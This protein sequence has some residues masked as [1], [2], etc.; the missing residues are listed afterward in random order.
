MPQISPDF[1]PAASLAGGVLIGAAATLYLACSGR[2]SGLSSIIRGTLLKSQGFR[3]KSTFLGG[4]GCGAIVWE[5]IQPTVYGPVIEASPSASTAVPALAGTL[6]GFGTMLANGCTS[7]HGVCGLPRLSKRSF[8]AVGTFMATGVA[9][10]VAASKTNSFGLSGLMRTSTQRLPIISV[11]YAAAM[12]ALPAWA[13]L[14]SLRAP[15]VSTADTNAPESSKEPLVKPAPPPATEEDTFASLLAALASGLVFS[16]GLGLSGMT[17]PAK[18]TGFLNVA[19]DWDPSLAFVMAGAVCLN[20]VSFNLIYKWK[21]PLLRS[22]FEPVTNTTIDMK[23][24]VG[25]ALFGVGWGLGGIC[26][27]PGFMGLATGKAQFVTWQMASLVGSCL[28]THL[29]SS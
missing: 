20:V 16:A 7:G 2:L 13:L 10:A 29:T 3:W 4:L 21:R 18:V 28:A 11:V 17:N 9:T 25:S 22:K 24:L 27:G 23:L 15:S 1:T 14:K 8:A 12:L 26:P 5:A 19:G 6:V